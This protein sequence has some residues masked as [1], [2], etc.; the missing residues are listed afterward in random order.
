M[1]LFKKSD[2][3]TESIVAIFVSWSVSYLQDIFVW[4]TDLLSQYEWPAYQL[5][6]TE[7]SS[8][9]TVCIR[10]NWEAGARG[11]EGVRSW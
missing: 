8:S 11:G 5:L 6:A 10:F 9:L 3:I 4:T 7:T 1:K 2:A